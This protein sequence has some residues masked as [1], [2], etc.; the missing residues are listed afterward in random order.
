MDEQTMCYVAADPSQ[1]GAAWAVCVDVP[2]SERDTAK[3][4]AGY[5]RDGANIMRVDYDTAKAMLARWVR[6]A[7]TKPKRKAKGRP[8]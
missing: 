3:T 4:I 6:P 8:A 5:L 2:G 7:T 1:P